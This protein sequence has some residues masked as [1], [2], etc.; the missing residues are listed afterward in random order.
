MQSGRHDRPDL[1]SIRGTPNGTESHITEKDEQA[2]SETAW[3]A[4]P[5]RRVIPQST[6]SGVRNVEELG[7]NDGSEQS[8]TARIE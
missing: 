7:N 2:Q 8:A 6:L 1:F 4:E 5:R 3:R